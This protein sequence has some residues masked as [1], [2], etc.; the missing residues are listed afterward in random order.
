MPH[1]PAHCEPLEEMKKKKEQARSVRHDLEPNIFGPTDQLIRTY[2]LL[3]VI[4]S[5]SIDI[6][7]K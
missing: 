7:N 2:L 3:H 6:W 5:K 1:V 4:K